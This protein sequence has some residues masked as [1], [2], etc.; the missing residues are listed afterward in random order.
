[1]LK[2]SFLNFDI[3]LIKKAFLLTLKMFFFHHREHVHESDRRSQKRV[4][5]VKNHKYYKS[6]V[7]PFSSSLV[8]TNIHTKFNSN[9]Q[10]HTPTKLAMWHMHQS[11]YQISL[12][13][14]PVCSEFGCVLTGK[15]RIIVNSNQ[16]GLMSWLM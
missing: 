16:T 10:N 1:M 5:D 12:G 7:H 8:A 2:S 13:P 3:I 4:F 15:L 14:Y 9:R 6:L 11:K